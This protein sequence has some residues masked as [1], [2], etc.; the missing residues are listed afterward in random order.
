DIR[1]NRTPRCDRTS[2]WSALREHHEGAGRRFDLRD[3]FAADPGR[4]EALSVQAPEVFADLSKNLVDARTLALLLDLARE[5]GVEACRDA[6]F[7]GEAINLTEGRAVM[8]T[9]LRAPRDAG[10][11]GAAVHEVLE[12]ML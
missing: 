4:F 6:M 8:H 1:M 7:A 3:A 9:A 12:R 11:N 10:P 2:A 5:C